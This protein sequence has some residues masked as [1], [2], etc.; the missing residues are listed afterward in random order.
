[1]TNQ[2]TTGFAT[3]T[4]QAIAAVAMTA[5]IF[6]AAESAS[7]AKIADVTFGAWSGGAFTN[8]HSGTFSHCAA[9]AEYKSGVALYFS[10]T[11]K[12]Q[13]SMAFS[14]DLWEFQRGQNYPVY[15]QLDDGPVIRANAV[16][17]SKAMVQVHL[18]INRHVFTRFQRGR[19]LNVATDHKVMQFTLTGAGPILS[20]LYDCAKQHAPLHYTRHLVPVSGSSFF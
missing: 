9:N 5:A 3:T 1:M 19:V 14:H 7:A 8:S 4:R 12:R 15:Y 2:H 13:W 11:S 18:P 17:K 6:T 10:V 20:K 16:A